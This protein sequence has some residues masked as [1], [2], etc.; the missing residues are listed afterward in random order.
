M[1]DNSHDN[2]PTP[3]KRLAL[4][5]FEETLVAA[6]MLLLYTGLVQGMA[7][8]VLPDE[9]AL[10]IDNAFT[11]GLLGLLFAFGVFEQLYASQLGRKR[12]RVLR[13]KVKKLRERAFDL[14]EKV[15]VNVGMGEDWIAYRLREIE[16][17]EREPDLEHYLLWRRLTLL[18]PALTIF[19]VD[20]L[21]LWIG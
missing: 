18:V 16:A 12:L 5:W 10:P 2:A 15:V 8:H 14:L 7:R 3:A 4:R 17:L 6:T 19:L 1:R 13:G 11:F 21:L 20:R 9:Q